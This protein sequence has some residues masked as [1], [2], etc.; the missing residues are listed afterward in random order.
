MH[1]KGD[2]PQLEVLAALQRKL[3]LG[4]AGSAFETQD[5]LLG[6]L[7]L[8][9]EDGLGLTTITALLAVVTTLTLSIQGGLYITMHQHLPFF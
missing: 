6:S 7:G 4:L 3:L 2:I 9:A 5:D 1:A 8:L